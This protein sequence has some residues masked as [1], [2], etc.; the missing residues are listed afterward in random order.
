MLKTRTTGFTNEIRPYPRA[1][2]NR[3]ALY[4]KG[5]GRDF[6]NDLVARVTGD[7]VAAWSFAADLFAGTEWQRPFSM[8]FASLILC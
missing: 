4:V 3:C 7:L 8:K 6:L 2:G 1:T 5:S